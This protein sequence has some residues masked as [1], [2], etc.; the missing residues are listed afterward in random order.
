MAAA[1]GANGLLHETSSQLGTIVGTTA[2]AVDILPRARMARVPPVS[3]CGSVWSERRELTMPGAQLNAIAKV[4][5]GLS[6]SSTD[7][8]SEVGTRYGRPSR[9][10]S[11]HHALS[12]HPQ[13]HA[14]LRELR[15]I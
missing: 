2:T 1:V 14:A 4:T 8:E 5:P 9:V 13:A 6:G 10:S 15:Q 11:M 12:L 3:A 7:F